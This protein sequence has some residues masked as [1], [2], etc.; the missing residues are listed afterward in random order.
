MSEIQNEPSLPSLDEQRKL[1]E[2]ETARAK[3]KA[4]KKAERLAEEA[5]NEELRN[6][7]SRATSGTR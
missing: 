4:R 7:V 6:S 2:I 3:R 1:A 5:R